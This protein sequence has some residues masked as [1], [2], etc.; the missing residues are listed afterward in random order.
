MLTKIRSRNRQKGFTLIELLIV[1]A[2]IGII[3]ALLI[4]NFLDALQKAK[5][6]RTVADMRN[7]GTA[8]FS[9]LTDQV[10]AAAA[11]PRATE[12]DLSKYTASDS[13]NVATVLVPQYVQSVPL[14]DGWKDLSST[15]SKTAN[16][17]GQ[18]V[19]AIELRPR[20]QR[21][22]AAPTRSA[23]STRPT[24][25]R[26]SSGP[27]A[28]S[29]AGRRRPTS[30][31]KRSREAA[32]GPHSP[33]DT[34]SD[35]SSLPTGASRTRCPLCFFRRLFFPTP[36]PKMPP[37]LLVR[38]LL[39]ALLLLT[40]PPATSE[41]PAVPLSEAAGWLQQYLRIDT[42]EFPRQRARSA[43]FLAGL[44]Q[45]AGIASRVVANPEGRANL[46]ARLSSPKKSGGRAILLLH[47]MDVVPPG[48]GWTVPPFAGLIKGGKLWGRGAVD[49]KSLGIAQ[50]AAMVDLQRRRVPL[51]RDVIFLA[52]ADE[53]N[54]GLNGT[55][56]LIEHHPELFQG[57]EAVI[58]EGGRSQTGAG[59]ELPSGGESRWR[60]SGRSG[61]KV[62]T[63]GRGGHGAASIRR[64]PI[65]SS[66]RGSRASWASPPAGA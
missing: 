12:V 9:W 44:L 32:N 64:A 19:M 52:V 50:L 57:V 22:R 17:L 49:D 36:V 51:A 23:A 1:V 55:G 38:F 8:M 2:I 4:P 54:G 60:R 20:R 29:S 35:S 3:A 39:A 47:H 53:E 26:T 41:T 40:P 34:Q 62:S 63:S 28:S 31:S 46:I 21:R 24:T 25:T 27:T 33:H 43:A 5:Q 58:G 14:N 15:S 45:R 56:W 18:Q 48:P 11:V 13:A 6:K 7:I 10:G 42:W 61:S 65:T 59:G 16:V 66:S 30:S 37:S